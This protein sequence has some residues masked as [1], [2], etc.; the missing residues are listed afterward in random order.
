MGQWLAPRAD[1]KTPAVIVSVAPLDDGDEW[2]LVHGV[3]LEPAP[4]ASG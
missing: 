4:S 1:G 3:V 2:A